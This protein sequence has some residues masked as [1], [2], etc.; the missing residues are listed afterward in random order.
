MSTRTIKVPAVLYRMGTSTKKESGE[1]EL[2]ISSD[3]P[4]ERYDWMN[5]ERYLEVLDHESGMDCQR[6]KAGAALLFN[7]D[8][9]IQL[10]TISAPEMRDGKCY[11]QAKLS[12]AADVASYRTRIEEGILK[13]TSV[14]YSI[15]DEGTQIGTRDGLPI[16]KFKWAP[17]EASMVTIPADITVGVGRTRE[18][19]GKGEL[20]E[21]V[22]DNILNAPKQST[23]LNQSTMST[24]ATP[25]TPTVTID[26]TS[27]R[28]AAV[29]EFKQRCK[30]IDD[31]VGG[32][33]NHPDWQRNVATLATKHKDGEARWDE[34]HEEALRAFPQPKAVAIA[35]PGEGM[36][37]R[38]IS[39]YSIIRA[40]NGM[41]ASTQGKK[42]DGLEREM[43][44]EVAK[45]HDR[46]SNGLG[47]FVPHDVMVGGHQ[48]TLFS[49]G[50]FASAGALV[51]TGPQGQ[52][53]IDL[54]RNKMHVVAMGARVLSG[55]QGTLAIP[56][57]TG[58]AT[59]AWLAE[60]AT[61][62]AS[63]QTVGQL[64]LTPHRL[65][66]ATAFSTQLLSQSSTDIENFVRGDL[67]TVLAVEKDRACLLGSGSSGEPL[68]IY[69]TPNIATTVDITATASIT[70]AEA[71][72]FETNVAAG[73]ARAS[74]YTG[75]ADAWNR[76]LGG[77]AGT[78]VSGLNANQMYGSGYN[79]YNNYS[80]NGIP[81]PFSRQL[82]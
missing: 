82:G 25:T 75:S 81:M 27:E 19:E 54:Y 18:E 23:Q 1:M 35:A 41:V 79:P 24:P 71:V 65:A 26:P 10:G 53:M 44:D 47:F 69:N 32:L 21:I 43:S 40:I 59:V 77:A 33:A 55:L 28:N 6:L 63:N 9:D 31:F 52:S 73:N 36:K 72:Q 11:V 68:G 76:A 60:D 20:R 22:I 45:K 39:N 70:Y 3:T 42:F 7:H 50:S 17:H 64:T 78:I 57:Q 58:G 48:R 30:K 29:A 56:R 14:G 15:T 74:G 62:T 37:Q 5:D 2:S 61:I 80:S 12:A 8:R 4:Y 51:E 38:D 46:T 49:T 16:Y 67:M 13:D 34:F 66:A